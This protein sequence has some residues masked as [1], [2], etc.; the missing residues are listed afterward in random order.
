MSGDVEQ[1]VILI[2]RMKMLFVWCS[3][4]TRSRTS[5]WIETESVSGSRDRNSQT[6][7]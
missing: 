6:F 2:I 7:I 1:V 5:N 3:T 4:G